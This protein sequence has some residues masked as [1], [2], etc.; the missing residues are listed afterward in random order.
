ME[1]IDTVKFSLI[2]EIPA[3][4]F[5]QAFTHPEYILKRFGS[6]GKVLLYNTAV[7]VDIQSNRIGEYPISTKN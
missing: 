6:D 2:A 4:C 3:G 7:I 1:K 5:Q